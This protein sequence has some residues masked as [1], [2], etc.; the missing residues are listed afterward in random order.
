MEKTIQFSLVREK[1]RLV[2]RVVDEIQ[3]FILGGRL[4]PGTKLPPE[5]DLAVQMGVSRTVIRDAVHVLVTKGLLESKQGIGTIVHQ[6]TPDHMVEPLSILIQT[7]SISLDHLHQVRSI[8]EVENAGLAAQQAQM[9]DIQ[10]LE[11][12]VS[13][14]DQV[15]HDPHAYAGADAQFHRA[16]AVLSGNPLLVLLLDSIRD[17]MQEVRVAVAK[18]PDLSKTVAP[19]HN[20]ILE[21]IKARD[22]EGARAEMARHLDHARKLQDQVFV[23]SQV[24]AP[25]WGPIH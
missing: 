13:T 20:R 3:E 14:M 16:V 2:D 17:L 7:Q 8:L 18:L 9:K 6:I 25:P 24:L 19:D 21:R 4:E 11:Q 15:V 22:T 5:R 23:K 1:G 12:I 10:R